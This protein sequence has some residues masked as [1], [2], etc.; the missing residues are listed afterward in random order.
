MAKSFQWTY[1]SIRNDILQ[2]RFYPIYLLMGEEAYF[3]DAITDLLVESVLTETEKDFNLYTYYGVDSDVNTV[4]ATARRFPMMSERQ[5]VIVKEAQQLDK[6]ELLDL[7]AKK[8]MPSTVL[9]I[10]YKH[11]TVDR[12]KAFVKSISEV[13]VLFESKKLYENQVPPFITS[14]FKEKGI[15]IDLKSAQMLTDHVGNNISQLIPQLQKLEV[16]LANLDNGDRRVTSDLIEKNVGISKDYNNFELLKAI[17]NKEVVMANRIVNYF[18][19]NPKDYSMMA[20]VS[21]LFNY[22]SN[23]LE[24]FWLPR[25]DEQSIMNALNLRSTFF[26]R[27]Y[28]VGLRHYNARKVMDIIADLRTFD[29]RSKGVDNVSASQGELLKELLFRIMH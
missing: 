5:L 18:G 21:V 15:A 29:A 19:T 10:N 24:C 22:F 23:L 14:W 12:R 4:I 6:L 20:T 3:I 1:E 2:R 26:V 17:I 16:S 7:Y 11:G 13:G 9:V 28:L 27:D 25:K 8:P